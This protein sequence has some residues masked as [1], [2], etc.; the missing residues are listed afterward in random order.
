MTP[1]EPMR[2]VL[3]TA[4][5]WPIM[6]SGA[7]LAIAR[8]IVM[9]GHPIALKTQLIG[10]PRQIERISQGLGGRGAGGNR[11]EIEDG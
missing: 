10:V 11:G 6:M 9:F 7:E 2:M 4:A 3:V 8:Q 1:P 5:I